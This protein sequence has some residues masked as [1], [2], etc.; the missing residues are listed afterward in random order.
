VP[1]EDVSRILLDGTLEVPIQRVLRLRVEEMLR[2][3][4]HRVPSEGL[5]YRVTA[6]DG[7]RPKR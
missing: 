3:W 7:R 6:R 1:V 5:N 2:S 4:G